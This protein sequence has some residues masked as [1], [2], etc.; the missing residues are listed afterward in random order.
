MFPVD[1]DSKLID[2]DLTA[3][4]G[5]PYPTGYNGSFIKRHQQAKVGE[6]RA[7]VHNRF[8]LIYLVTNNVNMNAEQKECLEEKVNKEGDLSDLLEL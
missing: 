1:G 5:E 4:V 6:P 7:I 2:F 8:S 3:C